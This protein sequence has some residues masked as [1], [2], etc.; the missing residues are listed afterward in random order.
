[1]PPSG[2]VPSAG[3]ESKS[4]RTGATLES[5]VSLRGWEV[6]CTGSI[7]F[8]TQAEL[9]QR[10]ASQRAEGALRTTAYEE[11]RRQYHEINSSQYVLNTYYVPFTSLSAL[12]LPSLK[13]NHRGPRVIKEMLEVDCAH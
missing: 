3:S 12:H 2:E 5:E 1:M 10:I 6:V 4:G 8:N 11:G 13:S 7:Q 9:A